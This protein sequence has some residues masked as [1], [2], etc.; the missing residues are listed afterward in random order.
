MRLEIKKLL[1]RQH[2]QFSIC[3]KNEMTLD[4]FILRSSSF[5]TNSDHPQS[6]VISERSWYLTSFCVPL[7][8]RIGPGFLLWNFFLHLAAIMFWIFPDRFLN[9]VPMSTD[10]FCWSLVREPAVQVFV[11]CSLVS[12]FLFCD[13][14]IMQ[15][16]LKI[17]SAFYPNFIT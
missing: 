1:V 9:R 12:P 11:T 7:F 5:F 17:K 3:T 16:P 2:S 8:L 6:R 15:F 4:C 14:I 13:Y 10:S